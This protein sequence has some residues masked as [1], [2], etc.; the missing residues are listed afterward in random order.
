MN[1]GFAV[2]LVTV[3]GVIGGALLVAAAKF[4]AVEE[5][6]RIEEVAACLAG[7]NCG[8]C[9]YAGCA[10][11]AKAVVAGEVACD[12]CAPGGAEASMKIA[13]IMG[14]TVDPNAIKKAVVAC[15][16]SNENCKIAFDYSGLQSCAAA[17]AENGGPKACKFACLGLGDCTKAC[18][19]DA[20]HVV[21]GVAVVDVQ[22]CTG[23]SACAATCPRGIISIQTAPKKPMVRC[24]SQAKGPAFM[25]DCSTFCI[26]CGMCERNCPKDAI[27]VVNNVARIDYDKCVGCGICVSKCP[28]KI[29]KYPLECLK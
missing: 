16:G 23:C 8:G 18:K 20:I 10:D 15:Q 7:A 9:G 14:Q 29:I 12:K 25:K 13:A 11:Y 6:P 27:H 28:K 1:I 19:F 5:D 26:A 22:K 2:I 3:V 24:S 4:M 21:N 17:A